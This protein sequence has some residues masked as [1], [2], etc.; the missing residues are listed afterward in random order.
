MGGGGKEKGRRR[1]FG[2][3]GGGG[4]GDVLQR[5]SQVGCVDVFALASNSVV[6][7]TG[8]FAVAAAAASSSFPFFIAAAVA[9]IPAAPAAESFARASTTRAS[10]TSPFTVFVSPSSFFSSSRILNTSAFSGTSGAAHSRKYA[11]SRRRL[12]QSMRVVSC[13][14]QT[15]GPEEENTHSH[16]RAPDDK[17]TMI[18][19]KKKKGNYVTLTYVFHPPSD[20]RWRRGDVAT[21]QEFHSV[22][23]Q[24]S[25]VQCGFIAPHQ[26]GGEHGGAAQ[27]GG[28]LNVYAPA[29]GEIIRGDSRRTPG[30]SR[31]TQSFSLGLNLE[32]KKKN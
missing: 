5:R 6:E 12:V 19:A 21:W 20:G 14:P 15:Y 2:G 25:S 31:F 30:A 3:G 23:A 28:G 17:M 18:A 8:F 32:K 10:F 7:V 16:A 29:C 26:G 11:R 27:D 4:G 22:Q 9:T 1:W 13:A 24:F